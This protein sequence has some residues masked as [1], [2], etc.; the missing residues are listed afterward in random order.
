[1][2]NLIKDLHTKSDTLNLIEEKVEK[3]LKL[4]GMGEN[5]LNRKNSNN[6]GS[7]LIYRQMGSCK[8][9]KVL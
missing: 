2:S 8:I 6:S 1:M 3:S 7:K 5:F 4:I 9:E